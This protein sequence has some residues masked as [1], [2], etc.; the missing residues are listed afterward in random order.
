MSPYLFVLIREYFSRLLAQLGKNDDFN[1][2]P[3]CQKLGIT[4]LGFADDLLLFSRGDMISVKLMSEAFD[5]FSKATGL[6][7]NLTKCQIYF[8][9]VSNRE[10]QE[11]LNLIGYNEASL[12]LRYLGVPLSTK[13]LTISQCKP[14]ID[15]VTARINS[16][17]ARCL[18]YA[19]REQL[20]KSVLLS[21]QTYWAQ[22]FVLPQRVMKTIEAICRSFLWTGKA[23]NSRKALI[24][25]EKTCLPRSAGGLSIVDIKLWNR[26]AI[27]KHT[28]DLS[29]HKEKLWIKWIHIY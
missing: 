5:K 19:G 29:Q 23:S 24:A 9:G 1:Y 20:I 3:R 26:L 28:W 8:G 27:C 7:A 18:S 16:W 15:K 6:K 22:I 11:I 21:L 17:M 10:K 25:W 14:L 12:P 4:H 13:R 2:H